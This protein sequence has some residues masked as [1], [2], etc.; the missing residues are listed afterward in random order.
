MSDQG[1]HNVEFHLHVIDA[2]NYVLKLYTF[3]IHV[4]GACSF[5]VFKFYGY[6]VILI[7]LFQEHGY[8]QVKIGLTI[9]AKR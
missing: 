7:L 5:P 6:N 2:L 8:L 9:I 3:H 4:D 1:V